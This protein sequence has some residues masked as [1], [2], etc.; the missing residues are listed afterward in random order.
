MED[1]GLD[2]KIIFKRIFKTFNRETWTVLIWPTILGMA[3]PCK[4]GNEPSG[5]IKCGKFL[6]KLRAVNFSG[7]TPM[8]VVS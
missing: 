4:S 2:G 8:H 5:L 7:T 6:D 3:G 1:L